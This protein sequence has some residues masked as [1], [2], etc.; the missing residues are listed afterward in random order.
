[1][2]NSTVHVKIHEYFNMTMNV[3][4]IFKTENYFF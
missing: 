3:P 2:H 1:M 4:D